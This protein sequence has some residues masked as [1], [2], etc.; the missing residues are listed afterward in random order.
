MVAITQLHTAQTIIL[1]FASFLR[2]ELR[3]F[4]YRRRGAPDVERTHGQLRARFTD[5]LRGNNTHRL[6]VLGGFTGGQITTVTGHT[7]TLLGFTG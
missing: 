3:L 2:L 7:H 5:R 4:E 1:N 6:T